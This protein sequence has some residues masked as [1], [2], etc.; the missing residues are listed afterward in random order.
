MSATTHMRNSVLNPSS[1][2]GV[3]N[4]IANIVARWRAS[5]QRLSLIKD[6]RDLPTE[7]IESQNRK[8]TNPTFKE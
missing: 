4:P 6:F 5:L 2:N 1:R 3:E 8:K 7:N